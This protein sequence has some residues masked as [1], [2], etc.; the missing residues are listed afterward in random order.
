MK[1]FLKY[2]ALIFVLSF[3]FYTSYLSYIFYDL[4]VWNTIKWTYYSYN[5]W[6]DLFIDWT[7]AKD[8]LLDS[9]KEKYFEFT[10]EKKAEKI[11]QNNRVKKAK[12]E[13]EENIRKKEQEKTRKLLELIPFILSFLT[14]LWISR[15]SLNII[16]WV[17]STWNKVQKWLNE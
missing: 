5:I 2:L 11:S 1:K 17:F 8:N 9:F 13:K 14:F 12:A 3:S 6:K 16:I 4:I 7:Q 10:D 15:F